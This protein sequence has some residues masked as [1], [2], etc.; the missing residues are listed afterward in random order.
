MRDREFVN[1]E[2]IDD[3]LVVLDLLYKRWGDN[4]TRHIDLRFEEF[5]PYVEIGYHHDF[6]YSRYS[7]FSVTQRVVDA[8]LSRYLVEGKPQWGYT[9]MRQLSITN[10]GGDRLYDARKLANADERF[11]S[12]LW[13]RS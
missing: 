8:L 11:I 3:L 5:G 2:P 4:T 12:A 6:S 1:V 9:D 13:L 7:R 10:R